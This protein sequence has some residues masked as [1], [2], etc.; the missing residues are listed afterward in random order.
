MIRQRGAP[1]RRHV[2]IAALLL[3]SF[4]HGAAADAP[5]QISHQ[6]VLLDANR[7]IVPNGLYTIDFEIFPTPA[8]G[9]YLFR[10]TIQVNVVDGV[11]NVL[12]SDTGGG[13][14]NFATTFAHTDT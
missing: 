1:M 12:L 11:Y 2:C 8:G 4:A 9:S 13:T 7:V 5:R 3:L 10:Q 14:Q 6:G